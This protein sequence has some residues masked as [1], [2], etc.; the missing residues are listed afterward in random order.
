MKSNG[1][2]H[3]KLLMPYMPVKLTLVKKFFA[4]LYSGKHDPFA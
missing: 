1:D 3:G 4:K 2:W